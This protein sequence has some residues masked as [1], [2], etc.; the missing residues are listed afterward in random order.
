MK[1]NIVMKVTDIT[2]QKHNKGRVSVYLDGKYAFSLDE[3]DAY[4]LKIKIGSSLTEADVERCNTESNL[5]KA[6][7]KAADI[8]SRKSATKAEIMKKLRD[9]GYDEEIVSSA[10]SELEELGYINDYD[11][12]ML[13]MDY[14]KEK[15]YGEKKI[16]YELA[17]K[18]VDQFIIEDVLEKMHSPDSKELAQKIYSKYGCID[19]TDIKQ[20]QRV[21]RYLASRGFEFSQI[22]DALKEYLR[23][24]KE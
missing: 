20:K 19:L 4:R 14:A 2:P 6:I 16:C 24:D 11:Y 3:V 23:R 18:G 21:A 15:C 13:Y 5:S 17:N 10:V 12:A 8:L 9:K 22:N 1:N 7:A